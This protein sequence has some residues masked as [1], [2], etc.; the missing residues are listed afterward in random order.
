V[1]I[2]ACL[3]RMASY[4]S[5]DRFQGRRST[6]DTSHDRTVRQPIARLEAASAMLRRR[7]RVM[8]GGVHHERTH[9]LPVPI[10]PKYLRYKGRIGGLMRKIGGL[11]SPEGRLDGYCPASPGADYAERFPSNQE[12]G[13]SGRFEAKIN[14]WLLDFLSGSRRSH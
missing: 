11:N 1:R 2:E 3:S 5:S 6:V 13:L 8:V 14:R 4:T 12:F 10:P 9:A 7:Q